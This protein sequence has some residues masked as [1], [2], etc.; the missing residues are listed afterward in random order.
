M[1]LAGGTGTRLW[2]LAR[3]SRPKQFL[4]LFRGRS[5]FQR[6][7]SR[8][9]ALTGRD[10]I[11]VVAGAGHRR[12][13]REQAPALRPADL[14]VEEIGRNTAPSV[15]LAALWIRARYGDALMVMLPSDHWI[16]PMSQFLR[17]VRRGIAA[18][19]ETDDLLTIGIRPRWA[20]TGYGYIRPAGGR[21]SPGVQAIATF[22]EKPSRPAARRLV[23]SGGSFW[24]SGIFVW[25]A[26]RIL[27]EVQR[28]RPDLL[29][30][31]EPWARAASRRPWRVPA[32]ILR[33]APAVPI[34]RAVL[35]R[36]D[37][38]LMATGTFDW[39]DLGTWASVFVRLRGGGSR[40]VGIGQ[41]LSLG[42]SG[43]LVVNEDGL[44]VLVGVRD[45]IAVRSGDVMLICRRTETQRVREVV[46]R[47]GTRFAAYR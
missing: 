29:K 15:V 17:V 21:I 4:P 32:S 33:R 1:I 9:R 19:R 5:L 39:S 30:V 38:I 7:W 2:P 40:N 44:T 18:V 6:T 42:S 34:D 35:E 20:E 12:W 25:R 22:V 8:A 23:R 3:V 13:L 16:S 31:L 46:D 11:L 26:S 45:L 10:G 41:R 24:N 36:S 43:C 47:L 27:R 37:R 28:H 14:I